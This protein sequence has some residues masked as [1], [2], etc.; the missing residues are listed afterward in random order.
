VIGLILGNKA[1]TENEIYI[2]NQNL[3]INTYWLTESP[4]L[5]Q[6][7][8]VASWGVL[9]EVYGLRI[10]LS[11]KDAKTILVEMNNDIPNEWCVLGSTINRQ[12]FAMLKMRDRLVSPF[13]EYVESSMTDNV[14]IKT[15]KASGVKMINPNANISL[16]VLTLPEKLANTKIIASPRIG[17]EGIYQAD[18]IKMPYEMDNCKIDGT[19]F[20]CIQLMEINKAGFETRVNNAVK[21][22]SQEEFIRADE[23]PMLEKIIKSIKTKPKES[24]KRLER[25]IVDFLTNI[26]R[27]QGSHPVSILIKGQLWSNNMREVISLIEEGISVSSFSHKNIWVNIDE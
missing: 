25:I 13:P 24:K 8:L 27:N 10:S 19:W 17:H 5:E 9:S 1:I 12:L 26:P 23:H 21:F 22:I 14:R 15:A 20:T 4:T 2:D 7:G 11:I 18:L 16:A 3:P 6:I